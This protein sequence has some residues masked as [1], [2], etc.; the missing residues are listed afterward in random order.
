MTQEQDMPSRRKIK[1]FV[2]CCVLMDY[3]QGREGSEDAESILALAEKGAIECHTS[4]VIICTLAYLFEKHKVTSRTE[5]P[6][7]IKSLTEIVSILSVNDDDISYAIDNSKGDFEDAVEISCANKVCD[8]IITNNISHFK[9]IS[10][11]PVFSPG[12][13]LLSSTDF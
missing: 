8:C 1:A 6:Q 9:K 3:F 7:I 12:D 5:I 2:D 4:S 13:F 11:L 10:S